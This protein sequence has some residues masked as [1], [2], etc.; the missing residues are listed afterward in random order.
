MKKKGALSPTEK[1]TF[2]ALLI[3]MQVVLGNLLQIPLPT[4]QFSLGFLPIAVAG[5]FFGIPAGVLVGGLGDLIGA[6]LFPAGAYFYGFTITNALVGLLYGLVLHGRKLTLVRMSIAV[7]AT[8]AC[9]LFLNS[10]WL[11]YFVSRSYGAL[12]LSRAPTYLIDIPIA[13]VVLSLI[14]PY[15]E[16]GKIPIVGRVVAAENKR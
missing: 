10:Y 11:T 16:S 4:K 1:I 14:L 7:L 15:L 9:N 13:I 2:V 8:L 3:A 6:H 12:L 5:A